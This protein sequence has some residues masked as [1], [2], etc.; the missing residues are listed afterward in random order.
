MVFTD[1]NPL[2]YVLSSAKLNTTGL[3]WVGELADFNF[4]IKYQPGKCHIDADSFSRM[5]FD[6]N[7]YMPECT[8]SI[9]EET[10]KTMYQ[11]AEAI[12]VGKSPWIMASVLKEELSKHNAEKVSTKKEIDLLKAQPEDRNIHRI[13]ELKSTDKKST[14]NEKK[15]ESPEVRQYLHEMSRLFLP[16]D[17]LL[18][19]KSGA[20]EQAVLPKSLRRLI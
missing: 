16:K 8:E 15:M 11:S 5:P 2:T 12:S 9:P 6:I 7:K 14:P 19:R 4:S 17:G 20:H 3:R 1:N 13:I 10:V 18:C